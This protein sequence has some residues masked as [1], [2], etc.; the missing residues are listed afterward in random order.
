MRLV[1]LRGEFLTLLCYD[2]GVEW[3]PRCVLP[4]TACLLTLLSHCSG[5]ISLV[6]STTLSGWW[7]HRFRLTP[8]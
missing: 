5:G 2:R 6:D 8:P 7:W 3:I 1:H 4:L